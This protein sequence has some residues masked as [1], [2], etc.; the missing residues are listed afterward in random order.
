MPR[1]AQ[2]AARAVDPRTI[3]C[4]SRVASW[5]PGAPEI[6]CSSGSTDSAPR[7]WIGMRT[8]VTP[9]EDQSALRLVRQYSTTPLAIGEVF[10]TVYDDQTLITERLV[11]DVRSSVTH[12]GGITAMKKL[13]DFAAVYGIRE[14]MPYNATTLEVFHTSFTFVIG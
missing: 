7:R 10:N 3:S 8:V 5:A 12:A 9:C 4:E 6:S 2:R 1:I 11:D 14:Y 13:L